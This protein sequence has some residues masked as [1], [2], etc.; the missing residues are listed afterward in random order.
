MDISV[1]AAASL[2]A[3][4]VYASGRLT[5]SRLI[6]SSSMIAL[7]VSCL[8]HIPHVA[9]AEVTFTESIRGVVKVPAKNDTT[10]RATDPA[11]E[12]NV[13]QPASTVK[14]QVK[15]PLEN[16]APVKK[17]SI[18]PPVQQKVTLQR[19]VFE[20]NTAISNRELAAISAPF[21]NRPL[22]FSDLEQLRVEL[23]RAYTDKGYISSG[24]VLPDQKVTD[25]QITYQIIEGKLGDIEVTGTG[26]LKPEYVA[27]RVRAR[28]G[29]PFNSVKLQEGFQL[30]LDD[31]LIDRMDGQLLP[32]P[33]AGS[34]SLNLKVTPSTPWL[35]NLTGDNNGSPSVGSEQFTLSGS[36]LNPTGFGDRADLS[37]NAS[38]GRFNIAAGY[39]VPLNARDTRFAFDIAT[40]NSTVIEEPLDDIDIESDSNSLSLSLSHPIRRSLQGSFNIGVDLTVRD[41]SNTLLGEPFSFSAGEEDG[42]SQVTALRLWQDYTRK[43]SN[44]VV[45]LRSSFNFGVDAFGSTINDDDLPDSEFFTWLGQAQFVR[46][47]QEGSGE[48]L[49]RADIQLAN[50]TLLP[51]ER[52]ALGGARSVRGYRKNQ[53]VRDEALFASAEYRYTF[54]TSPTLG[55]WRVAPFVDYGIARNQDSDDD[56]I[57]RLFS[58]GAGLLWSK[59]RYSAELY[60]GG[61]IEDVPDSEDNNLQDEGVHF[62]FSTRIF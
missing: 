39:S 5:I 31:P 34:T 50:E 58:A 55:V 15:Q 24:A 51:L 22:R 11:G 36:Y 2:A 16:K 20:G 41:N 60:I 8:V 33:Q 62:R 44:Q 37:L 43:K 14:P 35:L 23:T 53:L 19:V 59:S 3:R 4:A 9:A 28:A 40:T 17:L 21:L 49:L 10:T 30:L 57:D 48:F 12:P 45:A 7:T 54:Y 61:A 29:E 46:S 47:L 52:F 56:N 38:P 18:R 42:D 1:K 27:R 32:V 26:R 13:Q 6:I 25:G